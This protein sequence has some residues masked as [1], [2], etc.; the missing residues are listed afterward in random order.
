[1]APPLQPGA[2]GP[3][4]GMGYLVPQPFSDGRN[5]SYQDFLVITSDLR[6]PGYKTPTVAPEPSIEW[7]ARAVHSM[8]GRIG[9]H[10]LVQV[11]SPFTLPRGGLNRRF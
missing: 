7:V 3:I 11:E 10:M 5:W 6:Y 4:S 8:G 1:V 2:A 9:T